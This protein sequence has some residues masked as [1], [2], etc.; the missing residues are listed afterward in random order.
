MR[1]S[2]Q[3]GVFTTRLLHESFDLR[4]ARRPIVLVEKGRV[5]EIARDE[6]QSGVLQPQKTELMTECGRE[7]IG[8]P[9]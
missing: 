1:A 9:R 3:V 4:A 2:A 5:I 6:N 8:S 7:R